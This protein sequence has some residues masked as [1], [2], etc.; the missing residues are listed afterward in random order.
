VDF[1]LSKWKKSLSEK[2]FIVFTTAYSEY[3]IEGFKVDAVDYLLKPIGYNDF[4]RA[5]NK[6]KFLFDQKDQK[7]ELLIHNQTT[8]LL[9]LIIRLSE[10]EKTIYL[11][12]Q[13]LRVAI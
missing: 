3:A 1:Q 11:D 6:V 12:G 8:F 7:A 2:P 4:L 10:L 5:S 13:Y 9:K